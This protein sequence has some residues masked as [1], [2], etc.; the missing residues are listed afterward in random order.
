MVCDGAKVASLR[1]KH[2]MTQ[3]R[4]A[5]LAKVD[6]RTIQRMEAGEAV[7]IET[8]HQ[9]AAPLAVTAF[10]LLVD[11]TAP[12]AGTTDGPGIL[13]KPERSGLRLVELITEADEI[14]FGATF[15]PWPQQLETVKPFLTLL[16][17]LHPRSFENAFEYDRALLN[18][19]ARQLEAAAEVNAGLA[20]LPMLK[21]EGLHLLSG[22][23]TRWGKR[24]RIDGDTGQWYTHVNQR[25]EILTVAALRIAP[26]SM[27][28]IRI[29]LRGK[30]APTQTE[31]DTDIPF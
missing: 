2:L 22:Q 23:Y 4:L 13:L 25:E 10:D 9:V 16:E 21:P 29:P 30:P 27:M 7:S 20:Q 12:L 1:E 14:D 24:A 19:A 17:E 6:R 18:S 8:L 11:P 31:E 28:S 15:E 5:A 26:I 3:E